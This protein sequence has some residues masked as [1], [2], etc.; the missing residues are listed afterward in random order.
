[1][2]DITPRDESTLRTF[3]QPI[4]GGLKPNHRNP[5]ILLPNRIIAAPNSIAAPRR[6]IAGDSS[7]A[8]SPRRRIVVPFSGSHALCV[9]APPVAVVSGRNTVVDTRNPVVLVWDCAI[10]LRN[11][12]NAPPICVNRVQNLVNR[13]QDSV[14]R[15]QDSVHEVPNCD[16]GDRNRKRRL[17]PLFFPVPGA[18]FGGWFG[19]LFLFGL[20]EAFA[21][22]LGDRAG[23]SPGVVLAAALT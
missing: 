21:Q 1:M 19:F 7:R 13:V 6:R 14:N 20:A 11:R 3:M 4:I 22:L 10:R 8:V 5:I 23:L 17:D 9:G 12:A 16:D 15:V 2:Q 18:L